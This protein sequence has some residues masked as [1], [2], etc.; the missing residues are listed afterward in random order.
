MIVIL[1]C[2]GYEWE[3]SARTAE[4]AAEAC[5]ALE[6]QDDD[7][8][9]RVAYENGRIVA[10]AEGVVDQRYGSPPYDAA[11]ATGMYDR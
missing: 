7:R 6:T 2:N 1:T 9:A 8:F 3:A 11:T 10:D 4:D 5:R